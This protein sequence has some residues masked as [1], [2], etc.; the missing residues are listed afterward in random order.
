MKILIIV[1]LL[2]K[3][4]KNLPEEKKISKLKDYRLIVKKQKKG[5]FFLQFEEPD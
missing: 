2:K 3:L 4:I 5:L 1:M